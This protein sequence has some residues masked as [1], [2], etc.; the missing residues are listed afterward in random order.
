M[1]TPHNFTF[2]HA[3]TDNNVVLVGVSTLTVRKK[4]HTWKGVNTG[5]VIAANLIGEVTLDKH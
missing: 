5:V 1:V 3:P 2:A 4:T